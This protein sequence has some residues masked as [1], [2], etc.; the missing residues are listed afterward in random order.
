MRT[1][2]HLWSATF[3][4][5][6]LT[7]A[8]ARGQTYNETGDA[9]QTLGTVQATGAS[10]GNPLSTISGNI[11]GINDA[12]LYLFTIT[13]PTT[14]S[15]TT[16]GGST[17]D[18]ALFLFTNGGVP[19]STND[20]AS[21]MTLQSTLPAG[22]SFTVSLSAG[23]YILGISLSGNEPMNLN[24]Q[25]L[26]APYPGGDSTAVRG[27]AAGLNPNT[28]SGF[29]SAAGFGEMGAYSIFLSSSATAA[30][31][32]PSTTALVLLVLA[33]RF[34]SKRWISSRNEA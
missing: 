14:F 24:G 23:T 13:A 19:I 11:S 6:A 17:L 30:V 32:E 4:A 1:K 22:S 29:N 25:L 8:A 7:A 2:L 18:T 3:V 10:S 26:F 12:D 34:A 33:G 5:L 31:P 20:D 15:A 28:L 9:G 21:G 27:P 16:F